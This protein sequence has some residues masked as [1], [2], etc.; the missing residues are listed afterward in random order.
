MSESS[1]HTSEL[2]LNSQILDETESV[3]DSQARKKEPILEI[4]DFNKENLNLEDY[5]NMQ[6][7]SEV[8]DRSKNEGFQVN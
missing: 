8:R 7:V 2:D 6:G 5:N 3:I 1:V 4:E